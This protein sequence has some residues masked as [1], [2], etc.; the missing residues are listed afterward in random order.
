MAATPWRSRTAA[1]RRPV[2][3]LKDDTVD[4]DR[5]LF[6]SINHLAGSTTW[7]HS[8]MAAY[9]LWGGLV[10]LTLVWACCWLSARHRR[11]LRSMAGVILTGTASVIALTLN[12]VIGPLVDR[13]RPFVA[14]PHVLRLLPHSADS[15]FPSDHAMIAGAFVGGLLVVHRRWGSV[16]AVLAVLLAFARVYVGVHYPTDVLGGLLI[17]ATVGILLTLP[18]LRAALAQLLVTIARTPLRPLLQ[19]TPAVPAGRNSALGHDG[20]DVPAGR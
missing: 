9:A 7:A 11:D 8:F 1:C 17:G 2:T 13:P 15:S 16:A 10:A 19:A 6:G 18:M 20:P 4:W 5:N 3:Y 14:L 12:Q